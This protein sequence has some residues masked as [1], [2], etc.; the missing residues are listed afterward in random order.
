MWVTRGGNK[1]KKITK[2]SIKMCACCVCF[3]LILSQKFSIPIIVCKS[4]CNVN[5]PRLARARTF[6]ELWCYRTWFFESGADPGLAMFAR[7]LHPFA[8][9]NTV[10][11]NAEKFALVAPRQKQLQRQIKWPLA[12]CLH[13]RHRLFCFFICLMENIWCGWVQSFGK[14]S[15]ISWMD[16]YILPIVFEKSEIL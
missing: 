10:R 13:H 16:Q 11:L 14:I 3:V 7:G 1:K 2:L 15:V 5:Q 9:T 4:A 12:G 6:V 8:A